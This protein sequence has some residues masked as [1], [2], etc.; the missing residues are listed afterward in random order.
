L[1]T[2]WGEVRARTESSEAGLCFKKKYGRGMG[3]KRILLL[4]GSPLVQGKGYISLTSR[5]REGGRALQ[6]KRS[7]V[8]EREKTSSSWESTT[9]R[10]LFGLEKRPK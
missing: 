2:S 4:R 1:R 3:G 5:A 9:S 6:Q 8:R 10:G 7:I